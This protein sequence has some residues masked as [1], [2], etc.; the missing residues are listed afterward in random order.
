M[1]NW[2]S[3]ARV[4]IK[5]LW[6]KGN[7]MLSLIVIICLIL[8]II[9]AIVWEKSYDYEC[10]GGI[11]VGIGVTVGVIVIIILITTIIEYPYNIEA[12][13]SM[14][15]EENVQIEQKV[16]ETVRLYMNYEQDTYNNLVKDSDLTTLLVAYPDLNSNELVKSEISVYV[17]NNNTIKELKSKMI[18]RSFYRWLLW[19]GK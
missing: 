8:V 2:S 13:L 4:T 12:K 5:I 19:F 3:T 7:K 17:S 1:E 11:L 16:K 18:N 6:K 9:G 15:Q 14:Y 10:V